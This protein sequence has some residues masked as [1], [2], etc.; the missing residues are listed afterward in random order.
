MIN[1]T[2]TGR[3]GQE[4]E[5]K[6]LQDGTQVLEL[7]IASSSAKK[8]GET[9]WVRGS[10]FGDRGA[11]LSQYLHKGDRV[12][13]CGTVELRS[14]TSREGKAGTSL[15]MRIDQVDLIQDRPDADRQSSGPPRQEQRREPQTRNAQANADN[16]RRRAAPW[17]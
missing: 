5:V 16:Q 12:A 17:D 1:A 15:E 4:P 8:D 9:T 13:A 7:S 6:T 2:I 10:M 3:L 11:K 14:W